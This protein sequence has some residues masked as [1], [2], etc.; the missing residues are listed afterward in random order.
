MN[1]PCYKCQNRC[2]TDGYNCHMTCEKYLS[3]QQFRQDVLSRKRADYDIDDYT[4]GRQTKID[5]RLQRAPAY[6]RSQKG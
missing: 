3:Y 4:I 5:K 1:A 6:F 2:V